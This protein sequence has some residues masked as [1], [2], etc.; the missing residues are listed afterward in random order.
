[1]I[2]ESGIDLMLDYMKMDKK[3]EEGSIQ[4]VQL[5]TIGKASF[6]HQATREQLKEAIL[7]YNSLL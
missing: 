6:G 3:N 7:Y 1:M 5:K 2:D 4:Y